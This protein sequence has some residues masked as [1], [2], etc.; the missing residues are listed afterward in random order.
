MSKNRRKPEPSAVQADAST[1]AEETDLTEGDSSAA[2]EGD[3]SDPSAVQ[4]DASTVSS[5]PVLC[6]VLSN[7]HHDGGEYRP[8]NMVK[9]MPHQADELSKLGIVKR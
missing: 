9:L 1:Q 2:D 3:L 7:L 4:A 5:G 6:T 8:G